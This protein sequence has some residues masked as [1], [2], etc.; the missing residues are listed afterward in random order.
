MRICTAALIVAGVFTSPV[1]AQPPQASSAGA[2]S[3]DVT[4]AWRMQDG[5]LVGFHR[6][7]ASDT[8]R[9]FIDFESG[10]S[11]RLYPSGMNRFTSSD[12]WTGS[13]P[14]RISYE[15]ELDAEARATTLVIHGTDRTP[16]RAIR[17]AVRRDTIAFRSGD[18]TLFGE[19]IRPAS[20]T[21]PWPVVVYV[22]GSDNSGSVDR[23]WEPYLLAAN[24]NAMFVFD[25]RGTGRSGGQPTQLFARLAGDVNAAARWVAQQPDIDASRIGLAGFSQGG[26]VA[27]LAASM[28]PAI[29]FLFVGYGMT[30]P[31]AEEDR[32]EAPLKL[33]AQGFGDDDVLE[34]EVLNAALHR[35]AR[36]RFANGWTEIDTLLIRYHDRRWLQALPA[37]ETWAGTMLKMGMPQAKR[38]IPEL[39]TTFVDPFYDPV[40]TLEGLDIPILWMVAADDIEA[41]PG[42]TI[43]TLERLQRAGEKIELRVVPGAD[44]GLIEFTTDGTRRTRTRYA[45][46]YFGTMMPWLLRQVQR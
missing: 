34:F 24:G 18:I 31:V 30:M 39:F 32:L 42:P 20:G 9:R 33:R 36:A 3:V 37:M 27:P 22:H 6:T 16:R 14:A 7:D 19:L 8:G 46:D 28:N 41:P 40:P 10:A 15:F 1:N 13:S 43:A 25:K 26:W 17:V 4:G 29:R 35:A 44:H 5:Q 2:R 11:H 12:G 23:R 45:P 38:V 21:G